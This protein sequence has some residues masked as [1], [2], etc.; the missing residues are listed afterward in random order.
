MIVSNNTIF[1][2]ALDASYGAGNVP[3]SMFGSLVA[4]NLFA[5][6]MEL[7]PGYIAKAN[8]SHNVK[9]VG[10]LFN[11]NEV[12]F[13]VGRGAGWLI[14]GVNQRTD[15]SD[16][17]CGAHESGQIRNFPGHNFT[18]PPFYNATRSA[19]GFFRN[20]IRNGS[21]GYKEDF[22]DLADWA[23]SGQVE[24]TYFE[25]YIADVDSR[26]TIHANGLV[27]SGNDPSAAKQLVRDL[28]SGTKFA[29]AGY[30]KIESAQDVAFKVHGSKGELASSRYSL[31]ESGAWR[32]VEV[33]F[34][35]PPM[36]DD[37]IVVEILKIG[38]GIAYIDNVGLCPVVDP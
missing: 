3:K 25:G 35:V 6:K 28:K 11:P 10:K 33:Q 27:L 12:A 23:I 9:T 21:F 1:D 15:G 32:H 37:A 5:G 20:Y 31:S 7:K 24:S 17:D 38:P 2:G 8:H 19:A 4:N 16:P 18:Y 22:N 29:F 30:V 26:N 36:D 14:P 13:N 34:T